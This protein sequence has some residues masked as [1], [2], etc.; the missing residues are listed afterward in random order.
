MS[1]TPEVKHDLSAYEDGFLHVALKTSSTTTFQIGMKSGNVDNIGQSWIEFA[2]GSDPYGFVRDGQWHEIEIPLSDFSSVDLSQVNQLFELLG[3]DG[4]ISG[5]EID[6]IYFGGAG[7]NPPPNTVNLALNRP[8]V[9]SSAEAA[10]FEASRATDGD[11]G[12][13]WSSAFADPQWIYV[14]LG[15]R[16]SLSRVVLQWEAAFGK[17]YQ[18]RYPMTPP[19]G[20]PSR[21]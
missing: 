20:R 15:Q 2:N 3:T 21:R 9:A 5:I 16:Y 12:T 17:A 7:S 14:D 13:R 1:V 18:V 10:V 6:D 11:G 19:S 8:A 4:A